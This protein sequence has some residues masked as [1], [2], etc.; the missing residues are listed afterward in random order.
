M[1]CW[2]PR[3]CV[4]I[5][6]IGQIAW[7][8]ADRWCVKTWRRGTDDRQ[9]LI[10]VSDRIVQK[11]EDWNRDQDSE[12]SGYARAVTIGRNRR[13]RCKHGTHHDCCCLICP[14]RLLRLLPL[15]QI[16][17]RMHEVAADRRRCKPCADNLV[18]TLRISLRQHL[19]VSGRECHRAKIGSRL[20][21]FR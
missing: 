1:T 5:C 7:L 2:Y 13:K 10:A 20:C 15:P 11:K 3:S 21:A 9:G 18:Q 17:R 8:C 4:L 6:H 14:A 16:Y 12:A 19:I